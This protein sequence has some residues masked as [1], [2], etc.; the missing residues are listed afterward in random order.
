MRTEMKHLKETNNTYFKHMLRAFTIS[1]ILIVHGIF[2]CIW[3]TKASDLLCS[4]D[5]GETGS[6]GR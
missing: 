1:C 2:P 6:T 3:E 4:D 5:G